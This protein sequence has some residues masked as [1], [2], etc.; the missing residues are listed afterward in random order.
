MQG[1]DN[2]K[3]KIQSM[4]HFCRTEKNWSKKMEFI[5]RSSFHGL[6]G[7]TF[8]QP[9]ICVSSLSSY[10]H[11]LTHTQT[12]GNAH[13]FIKVR[14][15]IT[16]PST[17]WKTSLDLAVVDINKSFLYNLVKP[18]FWEVDGMWSFPYFY[19]NAHT[20]WNGCFIKRHVV[21]PY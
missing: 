12:P 10:S 7:L 14:G 4:T 13:F 11:Y 8:F 9:S 16:V 2:N 15:S 17:S 18:A 3:K 6:L 20:H 19:T 21:F 1:Q 5:Q